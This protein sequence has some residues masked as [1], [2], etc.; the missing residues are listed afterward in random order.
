MDL[1]LHPWNRAFTWC[2]HP[3]PFGFVSADQAKQFD[4]AGYFVVEDAFDGDALRRL[5]AELAPGDEQVKALPRA[6][7]RRPLQRRRPRYPD[8]CPARG[9]P[10]GVR[11]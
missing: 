6:G 10:V 2:D 5:D 3:G 9:D 1:E 8:G 4:E 7:A 11:P